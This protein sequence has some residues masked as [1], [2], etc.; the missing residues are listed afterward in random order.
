MVNIGGEKR[1]TASLAAAAA[2][3]R[4]M[5]KKSNGWRKLAWR[6]KRVSSAYQRN[7]SNG[8]MAGTMMV[9]AGKAVV[10]GQ[11]RCGGD[12]VERRRVKW[13]SEKIEGGRST[14]MA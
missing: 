14:V 12:V 10:G 11:E 7:D 13:A 9:A 6:R 1:K 3:S 4:G 5:A 2:R 8:K